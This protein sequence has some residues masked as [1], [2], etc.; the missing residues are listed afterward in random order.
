MLK[1]HP[2]GTTMP[3][4]TAEEFDA[5]AENIAITKTVRE[6]VV[7]HEGMILDGWHRYTAAL[8][9]DWDETDIPTRKYDVVKEGD[10][11]AFVL[12]ENV[13]RRHLNQSQIAMVIGELE[14][15]KHG[16][17]RKQD[18]PGATRK[19][20]AKENGVGTRTMDRAAR[21][22][23]SGDTTLAT[24]VKDGK[25]TLK[26]ADAVLAI[27]P[28]DRA[29]VLLKA[30]DAEDFDK[31]VK[32]ETAKVLQRTKLV[33]VAKSNRAFDPTGDTFDVLYADPPWDNGEPLSVTGN[34]RAI[35]AHYPVMTI[36]QICAMPIA[37]RAAEKAILYLWVTQH[38]LLNGDFRKVVEAWGF[39]EAVESV[40]WAKDHFGLGRYVRHQHEVLVIATRGAFP[41]PPT[42]CVPSS[43]EK[44]SVGKHS[45][46]PSVF[47]DIIEKATPGPFKRIELFARGAARTGWA[48][49][50]NE[51]INE[52][53]HELAA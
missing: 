35:L 32:T 8:A 43:V 45:A 38:H 22:R 20:L 49:F 31:A 9:C 48:V 5:L 15:F 51:A 13:K 37:A 44:A 42:D 52:E 23:D 50:G 3:P 25:L 29:A 14:V 7:L 4:M 21:V 10:P 47:Y 12:S 34:G 27:S 28:E 26:V 46:K 1:Q 41:P 19:E 6:P 16:G 39:D 36:D 33:A 40:V 24:A 53:L 30:K 17:S 2:I 11:R 18:A